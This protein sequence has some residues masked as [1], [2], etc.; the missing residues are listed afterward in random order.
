MDGNGHLG[1]GH[2]LS[3]SLACRPALDGRM[4]SIPVKDRIERVMSAEC[5][6]VDDILMRLVLPNRYQHVFCKQG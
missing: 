3:G 1:Q 6:S 5:R 2:A 4:D